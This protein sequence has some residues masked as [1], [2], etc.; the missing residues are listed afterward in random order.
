MAV[1]LLGLDI[2]VA[3]VV[4]QA[5]YVYLAM[6]W[7]GL[8]GESL[9]SGAIEAHGRQFLALRRIQIA[10]WI[11]T[12][13]VF[14]I[15]LRR[16]REAARALGGSE[17]GAARWRPL[18]AFFLPGLTVAA[19]LAHALAAGL[20]ADRL[21]PLDLGGPMQLLLF[22]ELLEI[23]AAVLAILLVRRITARQE[24]RRRALT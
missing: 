7:H 17:A 23:A 18:V 3:W 10:T 4:I 19:A 14:L 15:W 1:L 22:A 21:R 8:A 5:A 24:D 20:A 13:A 2:V 12:V 9:A 11:A 16:A 6:I